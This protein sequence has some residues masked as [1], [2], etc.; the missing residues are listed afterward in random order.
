MINYYYK[1][2][3]KYEIEELINFYKTPTGIKFIKTNGLL[4]F[5]QIGLIVETEKENNN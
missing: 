1:N 2:F 3:N 5:K 4:S